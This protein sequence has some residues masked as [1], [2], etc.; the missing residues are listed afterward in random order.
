MPRPCVVHPEPVIEYPHPDDLPDGLAERVNR[1]GEEGGGRYWAEL[2]TAPGTKVGGHPRWIQ[3]PEWP[4]CGCGRRMDHL[5]TIASGE[6][7]SQGRWTR[8]MD[9]DAWAPHG[10]ALGG[11]GGSLY[12]FAC[13]VCVGRPLGGVL[14]R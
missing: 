3:D 13:T 6:F 8:L 5:L 4:L 11:G 2:S 14:Q 7:G 9:R 1:W 10:I 12:L